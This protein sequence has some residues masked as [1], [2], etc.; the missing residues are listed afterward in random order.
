MATDT[1]VGGSHTTD[2]GFS[3]VSSHET[4]EEI[5]RA[6]APEPDPEPETSEERPAKDVSKA[7]QKLGRL[8]GKAAAEARKA[9]QVPEG[10][11]VPEEEPEPIA[12]S[13]EKEKLGKP[14]HDS[15]ARMLEATRKEA[16]A[17][18]EAR[19]ARERAQAL[20]ARLAALEG[21]KQAPAEKAKPANEDPE[22]QEGDFDKYEEYV[23][24]LGRWSSRQE[25]KTQAERERAAAEEQHVRAAVFED[26]GGKVKS[27]F[28]RI[29][30]AQETEPDLIDKIGLDLL[31]QLEP[32][33]SIDFRTGEPVILQNP[34]PLNDFAELVRDSEK[35]VE[36]LKH[37]SANRDILQRFAALRT[38][39]D[40]VREFGK[41]EAQLEAVTTAPSPKL[42]VSRAH[43]PVRPVTGSPS[44]AGE[45]D[46][47]T[48]SFDEYARW[49]AS[50]RSARR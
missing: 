32:T 3:I 34:G 15:R 19:E 4:A 17:K 11:P 44:T 31:E 25:F 16:E 1:V 38:R 7:A 9:Q 20:E 2:D 41:L 14:R 12:A 33:H 36:I 8:G 28:E 10:E 23:K 13:D 5:Q 37:V 42:V 24:A 49:H 6:T 47:E 26:L 46:P 39:F 43:P 45:P 50:K 30:K 22:P 48:S 35:T 18:R 27:A 40:V 29:S 21:G